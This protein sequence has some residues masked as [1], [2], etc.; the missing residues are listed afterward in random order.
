[1]PRDRAK[2]SQGPTRRTT[3]LSALPLRFL[4]VHVVPGDQ[5]PATSLSC[6]RVIPIRERSCHSAPIR[7]QLI[8][9]G[10]STRRSSRERRCS[11]PTS[12]RAQRPRYRG[13]LADSLL[14]SRVILVSDRLGTATGWPERLTS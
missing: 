9:S 13:R 1:M 2:R 4:G 8:R 12:W 6:S 11:A 3:H 5:D 14:R 7:D 10:Y